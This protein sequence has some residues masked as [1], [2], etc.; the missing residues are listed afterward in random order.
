[1]LAKVPAS[2]RDAL[3]LMRADKWES[4]L[5]ALHT[6]AASDQVPADLRADAWST[7]GV[8]YEELGKPEQAHAAYRW[9]VALNPR[10]HAALNNLGAAATGWHN[11]NEAISWFNASLAIDPK[12]GNSI[13]GIAAALIQL[14]RFQD[15]L[16]VCEQAI[17]L[18]PKCIP[19]HWNRSIAALGTGDWELG[20]AEHE[21]RRK[22]PNKREHPIPETPAWEGQP[23][24]GK[25][26]FVLA[27]QGFGDMLMWARCYQ[28]LQQM[29]ATVI[30]EAHGPLA[31]LLAWMPSV[32]SVVKYGEAPP[33]HDYHIFAVSL[34]RV[35]EMRVAGLSGK[36]Y[37]TVP[38]KRVLPESDRPQIG[39]IWRGRPEHGNNHNRSLSDADAYALC[40]PLLADWVSLQVDHPPPHARVKDLRSQIR[41]FADTAQI[42]KGLDV[43][44]SVDSAG[45]HLAGAL[46]VPV[47]TLLPD[48]SEW[49]WQYGAESTP[50]YNSMTLIRQTRKGDWSSVIEQ[51]HRK[52]KGINARLD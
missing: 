40:D 36:P 38:S 18:D 17:A 43:V 32:S 20:W 42:M 26:V 16:S 22:L 10:C 44:V 12:H 8:V 14:G 30:A 9:A 52:L 19:A 25:T 34:P 48:P 7:A 23:L 5:S 21:W 35:L 28:T 45:C 27:E 47:W 1:M 37:L 3:T 13:A 31:A 24:D 41:H 33:A 46:G 49:R 11:A 39:I 29:G 6:V 50:W 51:V 15:S 4:A 2:Y